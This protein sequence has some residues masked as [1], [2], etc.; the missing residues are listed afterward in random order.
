MT[1]P[2][3]VFYRDD[4]MGLEVRDRTGRALGKVRDILVTGG[5]DVFVIGRVGEEV[6]IPA[7][8]S[9]CVEI[10]IQQG[11]LIVEPPAGL[12]EINAN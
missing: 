3:G 7:V 10:D 9:I 1:L 2:D 6:L 11:T 8:R 12:L 5:A 4:L